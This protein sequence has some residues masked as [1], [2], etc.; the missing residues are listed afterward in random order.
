MTRSISAVV[1]WSL[2]CSKVPILVVVTVLS[3]LGHKYFTFRTI[4]GSVANDL[5]ASAGES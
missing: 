3:Y 2:F 5:E 1:G 4:G